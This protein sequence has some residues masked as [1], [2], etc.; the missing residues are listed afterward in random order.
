LSAAAP[1][2]PAIDQDLVART[3]RR[4]LDR[5]GLEGLPLRRPDPRPAAG[6]AAS[7]ALVIGRSGADP[8]LVQDRH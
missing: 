3:A 8:G 1:A 4:M 5:E 6:P 7:A 2:G